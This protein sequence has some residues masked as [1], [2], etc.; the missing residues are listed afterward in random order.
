M[1]SKSWIQ[2]EAGSNMKP[3]NMW[4]KVSLGLAAILFGSLMGLGLA[5]VLLRVFWPGNNWYYLWPPHLSVTFTP[6]PEIVH[7]VGR[8]ARIKVNSKGI[9]GEEWG[10]NRADEYRIL[11][12]GGSTTQ[13]IMM[14]QS[15]TWPVLL[16]KELGK[17]ADG[18]NVWIGNLGR[19]GFS[20][21]DHLGL[22]KLAIGQ[23]DTDAILMLVGGNDVVERLLQGDRYDTHFID[24]EE[25]YD[26]WLRSRFVL[27]PLTTQ[28]PN[29]SFYR[30]T[31]VFQLAR[32]VKSLRGRKQ[33]VMDNTGNWLAVAREYRRKATIIDKLPPLN[34]GLEEYERIVTLIA[35]EARRRAIRIIFL[36]Q[37][38]MWKEPMSKREEDLMWMGYA[39]NESG[40]PVSWPYWE[41]SRGRMYTIGAM[42]RAMAA[43]NQRLT[44]TCAK[45]NVEC[46]DL[47]ARIPRTF[48]MYFD[49]M[50]HT[51]LGS[52]RVATEL[53]DY[54]KTREPFVKSPSPP[55][56]ADER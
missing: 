39:D 14:D 44:E 49:D 21:R 32:W 18:R 51:E 26:A 19:S 34:S 37:P 22:M 35:N 36:T 42:A 27:V 17:T 6:A 16:Q 28:S 45:L 1:S 13:N 2:A 12:I 46:F 23:Y 41:S 56:Q 8:E 33:L 53:A 3:A 29:A 25:R 40:N 20:S 48:E 30:R 7:G 9:L 24:N 43:Y 15:K 52:Q 5:E 55:R 10:A 47:A 31:A 4:R 50:H 11:T 38:T 54:L